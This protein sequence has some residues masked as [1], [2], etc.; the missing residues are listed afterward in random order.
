VTLQ[1]LSNNKDKL[2]QESVEKFAKEKSRVIKGTKEAKWNNK[3]MKVIEK[4]V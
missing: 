4:P 2:I 3:Y 1:V